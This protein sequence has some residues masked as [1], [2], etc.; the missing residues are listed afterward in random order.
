MRVHSR[1]E[2]LCVGR[3]RVQEG[4]LEGKFVLGGLGIVFSVSE[5]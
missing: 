2:R 5:R 1:R 4:R 3:G